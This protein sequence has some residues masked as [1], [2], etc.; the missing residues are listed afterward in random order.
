[1]INKDEST[2]DEGLQGLSN[3]M[4]DAIKDLE[5]ITIKA[6][7]GY[8]TSIEINGYEFDCIIDYT[9]VPLCRGG[10]GDFGVQTEPDDPAHIEMDAVYI[11]DGTWQLIDIPEIA[12]TEILEEILEHHTG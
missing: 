4:G 6:P 10:R 7:D 2:E 8:A 5:K 9:F 11:K 3:L 12:F 1:M